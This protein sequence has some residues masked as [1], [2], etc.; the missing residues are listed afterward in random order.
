[1]S[2]GKAAH[3]ATRGLLVLSGA[4]R[5]AQKLTGQAAV[6]LRYHSI[7]NRPEQFDDTI[8][9]DSIHA[10]SIFERHVELIAR[11]FNPIGMDDIALFLKGEKSLPRRAVAITF[12]DG[13]KDNV[14]FAVPILNR[15]GIAGTFYL[16]VDSVDRAKAPWYCLLRHAFLTTRKPTWR[17]PT[18][19][20]IH[21]LTD[22]Q[23]RHVAFS[24]AAATCASC[25]TG[26]RDEWITN[27]L[28]FLEPD[29]FPNEGD[30][31]MNWDDARALVKSGHT[32]GSHTMTHPNI[33]HIPAVDARRKLSD[34]KAKLEYELGT[35]I[36][37]FAY[38]H[39]ALNPQWNEATLKITDELGYATAVTTTGGA[40][41]S[42]ARP[43]AIPRTY[44]PRD[45]TLFLFHL[46][47][48]LLL[49]TGA[50]AE[51]HVARGPE[52]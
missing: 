10:T 19:N 47:K 49:R 21:D 34:S 27:A 36:K 5:F 41:R 51:V 16:L 39:P 22:A 48:T 23:R 37:H 32:V 24:S 31:M 9:C 13:Y 3:K 14:R 46:E 8:G 7:Q 52:A 12:D 28:R 2:I 18:T 42:D 29:S 33:A 50:A 4:L 11:R 40:V 30:L 15:F 1:M 26:V 38:P 45:E 6:I 17:D 20:I 44:I 43:L 35:Q 25:T